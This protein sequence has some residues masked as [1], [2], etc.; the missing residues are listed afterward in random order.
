VSTV[1]L[2]GLTAKPLARRLRVLEA[3]RARPLLV[4]GDPWVID[5]GRSL[6]TAGLDV[7]MWAGHE[8][9]RREITRAR[10]DLAPGELLAAATARAPSS[11][12]SRPCTC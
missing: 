9:Q 7:L 12:A 3:I 11:R 10:L 4:G 1:A 2:Y 6:R 5:L 8:R